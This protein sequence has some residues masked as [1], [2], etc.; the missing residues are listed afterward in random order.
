MSLYVTVFA[1]SAPIGGIFAGAVAEAFGTPAAFL[2]GSVL[3]LLTLAVVALGLRSAQ[4]Q[5]TLGVTT[6][7]SSSRGRAAAADGDG[8]SGPDARPA[9]ATR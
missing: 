4:R 9:S 2:A 3:S 6:L 5:G 7:D 8:A 1:G